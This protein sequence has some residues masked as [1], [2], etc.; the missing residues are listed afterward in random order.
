MKYSDRI[1][2]II[3]MCEYAD[4]IIDVGCDHAYVS[5]N[6]VLLGKCKKCYA[7]DINELPLEIAKKNISRFNLTKD[8]KCIQSS[9]F[10]FLN[11]HSESG[12]VGAVIAGMGGSTTVKIIENN[13]EK[14]KKMEYLLIQPNAYA[15]D[16]RKF[17]VENNIFIRKEDVIFSNGLYYE[18][19]LISPKSQENLSKEYEKKLLYFNYDIPLCVLINEG[20]KY[21]E[22]IEFKISKYEKVVNYLSENKEYKQKVQL[23]KDKIHILKGIL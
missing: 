19:I 9:G 17:L 16:I 5:I 20:G 3:R 8:I 21:N 14:V 13:I 23:L 12:S 10:D 1:N 4:T 7:V 22:Y 2:E 18:Y 6:L 11:I 15:R